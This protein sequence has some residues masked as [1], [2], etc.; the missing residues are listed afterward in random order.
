M[1]EYPIKIMNLKELIQFQENVFSRHLH[2]EIRQM[3]YVCNIRFGLGIAVVLPL[4]A[5]TLCLKDCSGVEEA[6][7]LRI[8]HTTI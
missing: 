1:K 7:I 2:G 5:A 4:D 3:K 6:D 8:C